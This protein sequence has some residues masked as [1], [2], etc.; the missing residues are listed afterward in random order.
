SM[1]DV[2]IASSL[3]H[4][5]NDSHSNRT[6]LAMRGVAGAPD[7]VGYEMALWKASER[8]RALLRARKELRGDTATVGACLS[9]IADRR[10]GKGRQNLVL[11]VGEFGTPKMASALGSLLDDPDVYG[12]AIKALSK[13]KAKGFGEP[14]KRVLDS[15]RVAWIKTAARKYLEMT[16]GSA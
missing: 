12:H 6:G 2:E 15:E 11:L 1:Q 4:F 9:L 5:A 14:V 8:L 16:Q 13:L 7:W 3:L 10:F